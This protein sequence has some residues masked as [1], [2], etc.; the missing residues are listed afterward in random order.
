MATQGVVRHALSVTSSLVAA[1]ISTET[2][3]LIGPN[4]GAPNFAMRRFVMGVGG[5]MPL[6]TNL[7]EH[8]QYV[9]RGKAAVTIGDTV[10]HV[11]EGDALLIP[12]GTPH[13]YE[14]EQ[15]PFEFLC[16]VPN[17]EDKIELC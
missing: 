4:D 15:A 7:V 12:S 1:G 10:H 13:S 2:Q 6:H 9:V 3:V 14:V 5:G 17:N 8:E 16:I 11:N